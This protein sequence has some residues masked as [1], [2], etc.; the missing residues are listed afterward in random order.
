[1]YWTS[2]GQF[3]IG[4]SIYAIFLF[5]VTLKHRYVGP[6]SLLHCIQRKFSLCWKLIWPP[7]LT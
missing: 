6:K 1:L 4:D 2:R 5:L 7:L 3:D